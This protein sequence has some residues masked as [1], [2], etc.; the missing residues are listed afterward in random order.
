[1]N[2]RLNNNVLAGLVVLAFVGMVAASC[3]KYDKMDILGEWT[4]DLKAAKNMQ[5]DSAKESLFFNSGAG[6]TYKESHEVRDKNWDRWIIKGTF[7]RK[8]NKLTFSDRKVE[9]TGETKSPVTYKYKIDGDKLI[10]I[11]KD[12]GFKNDEKVYTRRKGAIEE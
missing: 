6:Q 9:G 2:K 3:G 4:I 7:E 8:N 12:E 1:M 11:V 10:L 5:V